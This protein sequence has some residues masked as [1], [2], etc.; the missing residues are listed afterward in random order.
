MIRKRSGFVLL[1]AVSAVSV[2]LLL[3]ST[4]FFAL[5]TAVRYETDTEIA[6]DEVFLAQQVLETVKYN[7]RFHEAVD[8]PSGTVVR[9][10]REYQVEIREEGMVLESVT[11][12]K[13]ICTVQEK[14]GRRFE[15]SLLLGGGA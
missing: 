1:W 9:N 12:K 13:I 15:A 11:M 2:V 6:T 4:A 8:F 7:H 14:R 10:G 5:R 3:G